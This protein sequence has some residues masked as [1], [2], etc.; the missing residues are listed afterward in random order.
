MICSGWRQ[1][2]LPRRGSHTNSRYV[3][4]KMIM[5]SVISTIGARF[6]TIDIS[7]FYLMT[8]LP[9]PEYIIIKLT[10]I[11][12]KIIKEYKLEEKATKNISIFIMANRGI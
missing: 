3:G 9:H 8:S 6:M 1:D 5:N 4:E 11:T 10:D 2:Q 12:Y 7:N